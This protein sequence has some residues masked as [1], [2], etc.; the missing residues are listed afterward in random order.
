MIGGGRGTALWLNSKAAR[1]AY[2]A[3]G[4]IFTGHSQARLG[5][6]MTPHDVRDAAATTW[7]LFAPDRI[8]VASELLGHRD[9]RSLRY[10]NRAPGIAAT[11]AHARLIAEMRRKHKRRG[12]ADS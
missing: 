6:R 3:I 10:Y 9:E 4:K 5:I 8:A 12:S 2:A 11:R 1:L 7:A